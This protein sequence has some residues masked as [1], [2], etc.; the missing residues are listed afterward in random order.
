M[1]KFIF[2][3]LSILILPFC[4][5]GCN[6]QDVIYIPQQFEVVKEIDMYNIYLA[7]KETGVVYW[8]RHQYCKESITPLYKADGSIFTYNFETREME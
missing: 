2:M 5:I 3:L 1:K 7:D 6:A 8:L 4:F